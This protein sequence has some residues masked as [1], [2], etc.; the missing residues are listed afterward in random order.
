MSFREYL[1]FNG[2]VDEEEISWE[3]IL[4]NRSEIEERLSER[5][6]KLELAPAALDYLAEKSYN[7]K[8]GARPVRR[9]ITEKIEDELAGFI[10]DGKFKNG[11]TILIGFA[12]KTRELTFKKKARARRK[13]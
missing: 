3:E 5:K 13:N 11:D 12:K 7:P 9:A 2:I 4:N 1:L 6:I 8:Y 10:L